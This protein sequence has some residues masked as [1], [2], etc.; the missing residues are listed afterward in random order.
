[1]GSR[2]QRA[3]P[4]EH[5][6]YHR[7]VAGPTRPGDCQYPT[8]ELVTL[9]EVIRQSAIEYNRNRN[10]EDVSDPEPDDYVI[11]PPDPDPGDPDLVL[12]EDCGHWSHFD[13]G[14]WHCQIN[15]D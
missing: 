4:G 2:G 14:C 12:C 8:R 6:L 5:W 7:K 10:N 15:V 13:T 1:M 3:V 11:I 9:W